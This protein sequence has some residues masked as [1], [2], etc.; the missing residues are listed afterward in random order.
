MRRRADF[1]KTP[2]GA[3]RSG[4]KKYGEVALQRPAALALKA[5]RHQAAGGICCASSRGASKASVSKDQGTDGCMLRDARYALL[6]MRAGHGSF[7]W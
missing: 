4:L 3:L 6:S 2:R 7:S 5:L 1:E